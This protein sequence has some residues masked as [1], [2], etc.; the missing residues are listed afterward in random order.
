MYVCVWMNECMN[1]CVYVCMYVCIFVCKYSIL[2]CFLNLYVVMLCH[3]ITFYT[4]LISCDYWLIDIVFVR[5]LNMWKHFGGRSSIYLSVWSDITL[6]SHQRYYW[7]Y[8]YHS[9]Y[10]CIW[11]LFDLFHLLSVH[12]LYG[13]PVLMYCMCM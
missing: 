1:E 12:I 4:I 8:C 9:M 13:R 7:H 5:S 2:S 11:D 6:C 3:I 10:V